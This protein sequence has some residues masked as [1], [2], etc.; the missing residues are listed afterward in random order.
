MNIN[1]RVVSGI[2]VAGISLVLAVGFD[3]ALRQGTDSLSSPAVTIAIVAT[4]DKLASITRVS[5]PENTTTSVDTTIQHSRSVPAS[6]TS[7]S[8]SDCGSSVC[9]STV[10]DL[11][12]RDAD[13][14]PRYAIVIDDSAGQLDPAFGIDAVSSASP[15]LG[16]AGVRLQSIQESL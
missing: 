10:A 9:G 3:R 11:Q 2:A 15:F 7:N 6:G 4:P 13:D 12:K 8:S 5:E 14:V 1:R 16:T